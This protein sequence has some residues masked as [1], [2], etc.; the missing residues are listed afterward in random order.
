ME[1]G[2]C[3]RR[4]VSSFLRRPVYEHITYLE[5]EVIIKPFFTAV[6]SLLLLWPSV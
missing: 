5:M 3:Y 4:F 1:I 6:L 2:N